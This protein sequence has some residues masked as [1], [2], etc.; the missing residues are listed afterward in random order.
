MQYQIKVWPETDGTNTYFWSHF[1][2]AGEMER[3][4]TKAD[5]L[6]EIL[7]LYKGWKPDPG[8]NENST[9]FLVWFKKI[10]VFWE[11]PVS[12]EV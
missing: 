7:S 2:P 6:G 3:R 4:S 10:S 12:F 11:T 8:I 5:I 1:E 9:V